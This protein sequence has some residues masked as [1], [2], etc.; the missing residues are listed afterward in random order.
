[1]L[2][3][4]IRQELLPILA[5]KATLVILAMTALWVRSYS[6]EDSISLG[7]SGKSVRLASSRGVLMYRVGHDGSSMALPK[8]SWE[9]NAFTPPTDL[10]VESNSGEASFWHRLG[11]SSQKVSIPYSDGGIIVTITAPHAIVILLALPTPL[12][13]LRR[14]LHERNERQHS[15]LANSIISDAMR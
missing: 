15:E 13:W 6:I 5:I 12:A 3:K 1:V 14:H 10:V 7:K 4:A 8:G 9:H 2:L 11:F